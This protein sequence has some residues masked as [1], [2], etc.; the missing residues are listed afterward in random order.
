M[1][2]R[3]LPGAWGERPGFVR[4]GVPRSEVIREVERELESF[5]LLAV[6][7]DARV[8]LDTA[9]VRNE[10]VRRFRVPLYELGASRVAAT[11]FLFRFGTQQQRNAAHQCRELQVGHSKLHLMP[12]KRQFNSKDMSR[13]QYRAR[14]CIEGVPCHA[15]HAEAVAGLFKAPSFIDDMDCDAEKPEEEECLRLWLWTSDPDAI[16]F[17]GAL[18]IEEPVTLP[19]E[20]Y[21]E[22]MLEL[23]MPMGAM[24]SKAAEALEYEV[25]IHVDRVLDYS[26]PPRRS[27]NSYPDSP[28]SGVPV[29]EPVGEWPLS[30]PFTWRLGVP[31]NEVL[32]GSVQRRFSVHERLGSRGR[33]RSLPH[34]GAGGAGNLGSQ[35]IQPSDSQV[36]HRQFRGAGNAYH[37]SSYGVHG[38]RRHAG[39]QVATDEG[40]VQQQCPAAQ[41]ATAK[42]SGPILHSADDS[43]PSCVR[44]EQSDRQLDPMKEEATMTPLLSENQTAW[45]QCSVEP[46]AVTAGLVLTALDGEHGPGMRVQMGV[47]G[48]QSFTMREEVAG[49]DL[50]DPLH[51]LLP[52]DKGLHDGLV[53][54]DLVQHEEDLIVTTHQ[55]DHATPGLQFNTSAFEED[56]LVP[57]SE[58]VDAVQNSDPHHDTAHWLAQELG[59]PVE[60][61]SLGITDNTTTVL[62]RGSGQ[63]VQRGP[64]PDQGQ[65]TANGMLLDLNISFDR[66]E[67]PAQVQ[68]ANSAAELV[69]QRQ[70]LGG[71][72]ERLNKEGREHVGG[73]TAKGVAMF[74][75]PL[76]RALLC[77][78]VARQKLTAAKKT[79]ASDAA[80]PDKKGIKSAYKG[81]TSLPV[82][83]QATALLLKACGVL[84]DNEKPTAVAVQKFGMNFVHP[85]QPDLL[86][87][88]RNK[89]GLPADGGTGP[90]DVLVED[91]EE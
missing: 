78:P 56:L 54:N 79:A 41:Q 76:K 34:G 7:I 31:D 71:A 18:H 17:K 1:D 45:A 60:P 40:A 23:G 51:G 70:V 85:L 89:L 59:T 15:R 84:S 49:A 65:T 52:T 26:S 24:R 3:W 77:N 10:A 50:Q 64:G 58:A 62:G 11:T 66:L 2:H 81:N 20:G 9:Q 6:Q 43:F 47:Q 91:A 74:A 12:W 55:T 13:F 67:A 72:D 29:D 46:T 44:V 83:D 68:C 37:A 38:G 69:P 27:V 36:S 39:G 53:S 63:M 28:V 82:E 5:G 25:L 14:L 42:A 57:Q 73:K 32:L 61:P 33:D 22:S 80:K 88:V 48:D 19:E 87:D 4:A 75:V 86:T 16:A 30:H 90:L 8:H 35:Q 21:A